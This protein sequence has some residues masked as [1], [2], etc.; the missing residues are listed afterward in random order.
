[1]SPYGEARLARIEA[2]GKSRS[3]S[4]H[5]AILTL[6]DEGLRAL[7][8]PVDPVKYRA[9]FE[10]PLVAPEKPAPRK[11]RLKGEWKAP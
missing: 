1:L 6:L 11:S 8:K 7:P 9:A 2:W 4:R 10:E 5:L 3:L